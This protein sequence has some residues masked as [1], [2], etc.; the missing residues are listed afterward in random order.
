MGTRPLLA[1]IAAG[2]A[3][4][5]ILPPFDL[6]GGRFLLGLPPIV[7][8]GLRRLHQLRPLGCGRA[9]DARGAAVAHLPVATFAWHRHWLRRDRRRGSGRDHD[10]MTVIHHDPSGRPC[11]LL[12]WSRTAVTAFTLGAVALR[13]L[14]SDHGGR[15][16][17]GLIALGDGRGGGVVRLPLVSR[18][19]DSPRSETSRHVPGGGNRGAGRRRSSGRRQLGR[20]ARICATASVAP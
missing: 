14:P 9:R 16:W 5:Q 6:P 2:I 13:L 10:T 17:T 20:P 8:G 1:L 11:T 7:L 19:A 3:V 15:W 18:R 4:T 12:A